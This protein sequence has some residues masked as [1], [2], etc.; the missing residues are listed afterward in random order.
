MIRSTFFAIGLGL[1][2]TLVAIGETPPI[3]PVPKDPPKPEVTSGVKL[4]QSP[5]SFNSKIYGAPVAVFE[6]ISASA[7]AKDKQ[8]F[9]SPLS[10][11][12]PFN[13]KGARYQTTV[14][15]EGKSEIAFRLRNYEDG[16]FREAVSHINATSKVPFDVKQIGLMPLSAVHFLIRVP[17]TETVYRDSIGQ[18]DTLLS[19]PAEHAVRFTVDD[20][21][22]PLL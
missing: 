4:Q 12:I 16:L 13:D 2:V 20:K 11:C 3:P 8:L 15:G 19:L 1:V 14:L 17:G 7:D 5:F 18:L 22:L 10:Q 6:S 21:H 9:L